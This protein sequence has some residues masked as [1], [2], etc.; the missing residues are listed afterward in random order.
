MVNDEGKLEFEPC[1]AGILTPS[2]YGLSSFEMLPLKAAKKVAKLHKPKKAEPVAVAIPFAAQ[3]ADD[4]EQ[5]QEPQRHDRA[6]TIR[7]SWIRNTVAVAAA[8]LAFF[9]LTKPVSNSE[10]AQVSMSQINLPIM[11]KD[12]G[13]KTTAKLSRQEVEQALQ[14]VETET[15]APE[16]T[17]EEEK[18][19]APAPKPQTAYCIVMASQVSQAGADAF[20][21]KL[22]SEGIA[23]ARVFVHNHVR[24][25]VCGQYTSEGE[26]YRQ[27]QA[28]HQHDGLAEAWVYKYN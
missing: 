8:L 2:L 24:R 13:A 27:L 21:K 17:E 20:V 26:A 4:E 16:V 15:P 23:D 11:P 3:T 18:E 5:P 19:D 6:I 22:K 14:K 12:S 7:M 28:I 25:V 1:E 9:I 10:P